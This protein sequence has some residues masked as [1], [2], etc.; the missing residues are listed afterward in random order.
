MKSIKFIV[1]VTLGSVFTA[2]IVMLV[3]FIRSLGTANDVAGYA[4]VIGIWQTIGLLLTLLCAT[5]GFVLA[6]MLKHRSQ[7]TVEPD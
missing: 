5:A 1:W 6:R 3:L 7:A 4:A 2:L